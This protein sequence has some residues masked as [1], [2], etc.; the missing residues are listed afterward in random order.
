MGG[1]DSNT[2]GDNK[3]QSSG[4]PGLSTNE[5]SS[6]APQPSS[7]GVVYSNSSG[8]AKPKT[9]ITALPQ[10]VL[11][12]CVIGKYLT[13]Q[14][15]V[16]LRLVSRFFDNIISKDKPLNARLACNHILT[17]QPEEL[18]KL[19]AKDPELF[20]HK[21]PEVSFQAAEQVYYKVSPT[22]LVYFL[23][24]DDMWEQVKTFAENLPKKKRMLFF[25]DWKKQQ[26]AMGKGGAD[27]LYVTGD[28]PPQYEDC[29]ETTETFSLFGIN[30]SLTRAL[31]KN[32][33]GIVCWKKDGDSQLY[34]YSPN[35]KT[36]VLE[37]I[38]IN[39]VLS[40]TQ[41]NAYESFKERMKRM[42]PNTV[43]RSSN[44]E[45]ALF[46][47]ILSDRQAHQPIKLTRH[48]IHYK[49][50]D[51]EYCDTHRDFNRLNNAYL[52]CIHLYQA[53]DAEQRRERR[54]ALY[55][56]VNKVWR[57]ELGRILKE[58]IWLLQR[59][60]EENR[61]FSSLS[62]FSESSF[63]RSLMIDNYWICGCKALLFNV[64]TGEFLSDFAA[65]SG[66]AIYKG[67]SSTHAHGLSGY[68]PIGGG[69]RA[70]VDLIAE[71]K[72]TVEAVNAV[73]RPV[74]LPTAETELGILR[75]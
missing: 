1:S 49:Q 52:K 33:D 68:V 30:Q 54:D 34:F 73:E 9:P 43:R 64:K 3:K 27:L 41:Q 36:K 42:E 22:D 66:F 32:P 59:Y 13:P 14:A 20:F 21:Y 72:L 37:S 26:Q 6:S 63:Q 38:D 69:Y 23:C 71:N 16:K 31:L 46:K 45:H 60:C 56:E 75:R 44:A 2:S 70:G 29:F 62:N 40:E 50:N 12:H 67:S 53:A 58:L 57:S 28:N 15:Q 65:E 74:E 47:D 25:E 11:K 7:A 8:T 51:I 18:L 5:V 17:G 61:P 19:L 24:D 39:K 4:A 10:D 48:G 35:R 55:D